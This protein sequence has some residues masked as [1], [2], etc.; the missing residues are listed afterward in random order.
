MNKKPY[1]KIS[2]IGIAANALYP[3]P[4]V[5]EYIPGEDNGAVSLPV[6]YTVEGYLVS[7]IK[8]TQHITVQREK[9]NG[10][11]VAGFFSTSEVE[12][13]TKINDTN[14]VVETLNSVYTVEYLSN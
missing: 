8:K 2:K 14:Y 10:I 4:A 11:S 12:K 3:T 6:S 5:E 9:R 1:V 13:L 7:P